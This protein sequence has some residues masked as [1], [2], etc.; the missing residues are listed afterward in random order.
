MGLL[1]EVIGKLGGQGGQSGGLNAITDLV[2]SHGGL[3]GLVQQLGQGGLGDQVKSWIGTGSNQSVNGEQ[4]QKA[5]GSDQ[6]QKLADQTGSSPQHIAA[7]LAQA[8]PHLIDRSTP[9]GQV[10]QTDPLAGG[11]EAVKSVLG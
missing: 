1:D 8:L 7:Q 6:M 3:S 2:N 5:L 4:V 10:P 9:N 11:A